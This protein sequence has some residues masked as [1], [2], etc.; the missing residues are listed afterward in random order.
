[1]TKAASFGIVPAFAISLGASVS[2]AEADQAPHRKNPLLRSRRP[3]RAGDAQ[4]RFERAGDPSRPDTRR[5]FREEKFRV[6]GLRPRGA[7]M[8]AI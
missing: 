6:D 8:C 5:I 4:K 7:L 2:V 3:M 1:M